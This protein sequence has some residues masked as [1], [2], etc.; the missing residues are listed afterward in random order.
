VSSTEFDTTHTPRAGFAPLTSAMRIIAASLA[1]AA[2]GAAIAIFVSQAGTPHTTA[3]VL[4]DSSGPDG[5][6]T[7]TSTGT[8]TAASTATSQAAPVY[9][10]PPP[11]TW[12]RVTD[13]VQRVPQTLQVTVTPRPAPCQSDLPRICQ[14]IH[15]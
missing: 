11:Q 2:I 9:E 10:G 1:L 12:T 5:T 8:G 7:T 13:T 15:N 6:T 4:L 3:V 14:R